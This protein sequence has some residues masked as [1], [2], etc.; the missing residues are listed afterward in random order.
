MIDPGFW[1]G[2]RVFLTG[3][4]GFKGSWLALWLES[5]GAEVTGYALAPPTNPS[6]FELASV[7]KNIHSTLGDIRDSGLLGKTMEEAKP[8][9]VIHMAAQSLV[10]RS[11]A[12]PVETYS[13]NVIG[14]IEVLQAVQRTGGVKAV[15]S[16][17]TDKCYE[18]KEWHWGYRENDRL[19][20]YDPYSSSKACAEIATTAMRLSFFNPADYAKHGTAVASAR[21]GNV[22]GG[23][24]WAEDRLVPDAVRAYLKHEAVSIRNPGATR[25]WQH[26]LEPLSGYML[27]AQRLVQDGLPFAKAWNFGPDDEDVVPVLT[28]VKSL[29]EKLGREKD[30]AVDPG[31]HPHEASILK[32]D[33]SLAKAELGWYPAWNVAQAVQR[34]ADWTLVFEKNPADIRA[35]TLRQIQ[36]YAAVVSQRMALSR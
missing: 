5:L 18:N 24:D 19:G 17:T 26:V 21:A 1:K 4:T 2:R 10:R 32:L 23:G 31:A 12:N 25:P 33:C 28:V 6:L 15:I 36:D 16:V 34:I 11:Y 7:G 35:I 9:I 13:V 20:G 14:T 22:I 29:M 27:L 3:H 30:I 8:E